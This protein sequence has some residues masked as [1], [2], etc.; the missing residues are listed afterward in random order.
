MP[1]QWNEKALFSKQTRKNIA[2]FLPM[3]AVIVSIVTAGALI[4]NGYENRKHYKLIV[5]PMVDTYISS[6]L[7]DDD[8]GIFIV[9]KGIGPAKINFKKIFLDGQASTPEKIMQQMIEEGIIYSGT[10][11]SLT[12]QTFSLKEGTKQGIL[13]FSYKS[14][15]PS[16]QRR[17]RDFIHCRLDLHYEWCSVYG[18]CTDEK[19]DGDAVKA[20]FCREVLPVENN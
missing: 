17:F 15:K 12:F 10:S 19:T 7:L 18:D 11:S 20:P 2:L 8:S 9:N 5:S 16:A 3:L 4:W 14:V 1:K 6:N 13:R